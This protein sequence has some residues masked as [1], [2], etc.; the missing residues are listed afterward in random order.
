MKGTEV[1]A[2]TLVVRASMPH[3]TATCPPN[4]IHGGR[5]EWVVPENTEITQCPRCGRTT[6]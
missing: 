3:R 6:R 2:V 4:P 1:P 5:V